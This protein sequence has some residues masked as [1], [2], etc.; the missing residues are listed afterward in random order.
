MDIGVTGSREAWDFFPNVRRS[1]SA[2]MSTHVED[3]NNNLVQVGTPLRLRQNFN[4]LAEVCRVYSCLRDG[5]DPLKGYVRDPEN[6]ELGFSSSVQGF[7]KKINGTRI[8]LKPITAP[9]IK[10]SLS[11]AIQ[12]EEIPASI[13][14]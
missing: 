10:R 4:P 13:M 3:P 9:L 11:A 8:F 6:E 12:R 1:L 14:I 2:A 7:Y 5:H